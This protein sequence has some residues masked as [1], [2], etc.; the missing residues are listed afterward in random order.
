MARRNRGTRS[1]YW[2]FTLNNPGNSNNFEI[3][4]FLKEQEDK[5]SYYVYQ[6]EIGKGD[7]PRIPTGTPHLQGYVEF[8]ARVDLTYLKNFNNNAHWEP[9]RE[10]AAANRIYC[11]KEDTREDGPWEFGTISEGTP[12]KR[13]DLLSIKKDI[14]DG[15]N[16]KHIADN[17][18]GSWIR[19]RQS[20]SAYRLLATPIRNFK[21]QVIVLTGASRIG[22]SY[23]AMKN[24]RGIEGTGYNASNGNWFDGYNG[25]DDIVL[26]DFYGWIEYHKLLK[27]LDSYQASVETKGGCTN[28]APR[29]IVI[30]SNKPWWEWYDWTKVRGVKDALEAR[31]DYNFDHPDMLPGCRGIEPTDYS[32]IPAPWEPTPNVGTAITDPIDLTTDDCAGALSQLDDDRDDLQF[33][34]SHLAARQARRIGHMGYMSGAQ[35]TRAGT[36]QM[37]DAMVNQEVERYTGSTPN[38]SSDEEARLREN[39]ADDAQDQQDPV[40]QR[41][42]AEYQL[43]D[44]GQYSSTEE[45]DQALVDQWYTHEERLHKNIRRCKR[46]NPFID[47]E[48]GVD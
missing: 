17:Y 48:A 5:I 40:V 35:L 32:H 25:A 39:A 41:W 23:W 37:I 36:D 42:C 33:S 44:N 46:K 12:G 9:R 14:D 4:T 38:I 24:T 8:K 10:S 34:P 6:L 30:T 26:D 15:K 18:F 47:D 29:R 43:S 27:L 31:I 28:W 11:T 3:D 13:N 20:F 1:N 2:V 21:S 16:D 45:T 22:K 7:N 19:N